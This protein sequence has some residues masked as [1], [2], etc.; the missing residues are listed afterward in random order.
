M[1]MSKHTRVVVGLCVGAAVG[2]GVGKGVADG[3]AVEVGARLGICVTVGAGVG[4]EVP[5]VAMAP[6]S[7]Q[8]AV[9]PYGAPPAR[10]PNDQLISLGYWPL[11]TSKV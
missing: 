5:P 10:S 3:A 7:T 6:L 11:V 2:L 8:I 4:Q 9:G 1:I